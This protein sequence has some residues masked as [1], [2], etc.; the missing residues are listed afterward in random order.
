MGVFAWPERIQNTRVIRCDNE[1]VVHMVNSMSSNCAQ[2]MKLLRLLTLNNLKFN[3]RIFVH[4]ISGKNKLLSDA[5]SR[6][7]FEKIFRL[8]PS[9]INYYPD[10]LPQELWP[11]SKIWHA[12]TVC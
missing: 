2:C 1:S 11:I 4:H 9:T 6:M 3:R 10:P 7:K 8:T 12:Q 5:L